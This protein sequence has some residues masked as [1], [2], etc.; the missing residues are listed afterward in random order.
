MLAYKL[1]ESERKKKLNSLAKSSQQAQGFS[2]KLVAL[3]TNFYIPSLRDAL[4]DYYLGSSHT[5]RVKPRGL[6]K[7][8]Q[9]QC[10]PCVFSNSV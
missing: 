3:I 4:E 6:Y 5:A 10:S 8:H 7:N 1:Y 2:S 9:G